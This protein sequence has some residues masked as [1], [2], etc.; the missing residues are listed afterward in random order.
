MRAGGHIHGLGQKLLKTIRSYRGKDGALP[1]KRVP[2]PETGQ[3][4][5]TT[6]GIQPLNEATIN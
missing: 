3:R 5:D 1:V 2:G 6:S 4:E